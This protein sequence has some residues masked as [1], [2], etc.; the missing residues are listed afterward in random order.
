MSISLVADKKENRSMNYKRKRASDHVWEGLETSPLNFGI[1]EEPLMVGDFKIPDKKAIFR[2]NEDGEKKY[3]ATVSNRYNI[4]HH[5]DIVER[6]EEGM[7]FKNAEVKTIVSNEG[8][9]M[10]R[11]YTLPEY[12]VAI[13]EKDDISPSIR[14]V[15]S[16]DGS[17]AI[18][19]YIDAVRLVCTNGMIATRQFMAMSYRH[20][21]S[22][23]DLNFFAENAKK[24]LVGFQAYSMN[25]KVWTKE[26]VTED[27]AKLILN[28]FPKRFQPLVENS[29]DGNWDG[30]K[31]GLYNAFTYAITH[32][33]TPNQGMSS[34]D[35]RKIVLGGEVTKMFANPWVWNAS[36][37]EIKA[38]LIRKN[39]IKSV[40]EED[41]FEAELVS[42]K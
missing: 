33:F 19:F 28:Y 13:R 25:W 29:F 1:N 5:S 31:W 6:L 35:T 36:D 18:G 41:I 11:I 42:S 20:F 16:Y 15:N 4:I 32:E 17:T 14:V 22:R 23:F 8:A 24:L 3:F 7:N 37:D 9:K 12:R 38:D 2:V 27:R 30:T 39:K 40:E 34:A 10:Q 26:R 21:G